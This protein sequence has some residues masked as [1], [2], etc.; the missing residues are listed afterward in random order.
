MIKIAGFLFLINLLLLETHPLLAQGGNQAVDPD[1]P[2]ISFGSTP[3]EALLVGE[4]DAGRLVIID[5]ET[6]EIVARIPTGGNLHELATDGRYVYIGSNLPGVTVVDV[7][8]QKR[9]EP[10]DL[11]AFGDRHAITFAGSHLYIG[12]ETQRLISRYDPATKQFDEVIGLPGGS[13]LLLI[14]PDEQRIFTA[15]S[16]GQVIT[17][18][19]RVS[20]DRGQKN[21]VF[22]TFPGDTRMEGMA[23]SPDETEFWALH[24]NQKKISVINVPEKKLVSTISFEGGLNNRIK[25]TKD[26]KY[27]LMNE[28]QGNELR[29]W[30]V[31]TRKEVK[32][33]D[34]G[35]GGEGIFIDPIR[36]RAYYTVSRGNK[37]VVI[38]TDTMTV[39]K[40]IPDLLNP[41]GMDWFSAK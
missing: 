21:L 36:P 3:R 28:L 22:T 26:G 41:D 30:D 10:I 6:L 35:A 4:K 31:A 29:V 34:V 33:I 23:L 15:S 18:I 37:L 27:V 19:D 24:M 20:N 40:E 13:H 11:S 32:R 5:P 17:I 39:I 1:S 38:D 16:N 25:F 7:M 2:V 9:V 12:H 14:T 8:A